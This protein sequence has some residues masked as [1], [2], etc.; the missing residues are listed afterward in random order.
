[1]LLER[2]S[3]IPLRWTRVNRL[4][5][6]VFIKENERK[7]SVYSSS[8]FHHETRKGI[9]ASE[10]DLLSREASD[11]VDADDLKQRTRFVV[12]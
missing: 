3:Q 10:K 11:K 2:V 12:A 6:N 5:D 8:T 9:G 7:Q 1:M 4:E